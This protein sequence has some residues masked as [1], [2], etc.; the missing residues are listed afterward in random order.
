MLTKK[1]V[2]LISSIYLEEIKSNIKK[3]GYES[4][5][6]E[7]EAPGESITINLPD[8][9]KFIE[10]GRLAL[11]NKIPILALIK[12]LKKNGV[13]ENVN[14]IAF[15]LQTSI[16]IKG[17]KARVKFIEKLYGDSEDIA[18]STIEDFFQNEIKNFFNKTR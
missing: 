14:D 10:T 4:F 7:I 13:K 3:L 2:S 15:K 9:Y 5:T 1:V 17:I 6:P 8:K 12:F 16:Y 18:A 11:A